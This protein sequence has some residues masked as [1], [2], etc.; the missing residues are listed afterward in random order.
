[1]YDGGN[2]SFSELTPTGGYTGSSPIPS[3]IFASSGPVV[4]VEFKS[5]MVQTTGSFELVFN[6]GKIDF[7]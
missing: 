3:T 5:S 4:Y 2:S 1:M 7:F 6:L